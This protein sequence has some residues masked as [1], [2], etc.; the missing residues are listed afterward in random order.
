MLKTLTKQNTHSSSK[1]CRNVTKPST[2]TTEHTKSSRCSALNISLASDDSIPV[3]DNKREAT[4]PPPS[5]KSMHM[6]T[7]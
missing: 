2:R 3:L 1:F 7:I 6:K 4:T 5:S